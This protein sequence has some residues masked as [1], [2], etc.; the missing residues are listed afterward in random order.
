MDFLRFDLY[1]SSA[2]MLLYAGLPDRAFHTMQNIRPTNL[3]LAAMTPR[4][5]DTDSHFQ[6]LAGVFKLLEYVHKQDFARL[7]LLR[8]YFQATARRLQSLTTLADDER[9]LSD[10]QV[11]QQLSDSHSRTSTVQLRAKL[12]SAAFPFR[13]FDSQSEL[14]KP[15]RAAGLVSWQDI[16]HLA[17]ATN[18]DKT[19][20]C[21]MQK[22]NGLPTSD[23]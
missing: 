4:M 8:P 13:P 5:H 1:L 19:A 2:Q 11:I 14:P 12:S 6:C 10:V 22:K 17:D 9:L 3:L 16:S 18:E 21:K 15:T 20:I 23:F 7:A